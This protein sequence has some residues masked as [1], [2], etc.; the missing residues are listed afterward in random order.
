MK[1]G[2][3]KTRPVDKTVRGVD[4]KLWLDTKA[5]GKREGKY[6][7]AIINEALRDILKKYKFGKYE[8]AKNLE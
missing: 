2:T 3:T 4:E 7:P 1:T 5:L 8:H 6:H